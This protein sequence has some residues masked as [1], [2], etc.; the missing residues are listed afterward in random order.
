MSEKSIDL[1]KEE[2][3]TFILKVHRNTYAAP[4]EIKKQ[5]MAMPFLPGHK[6]CEFS[7]GDFTYRDSYAGSTWAPGSEVIFYTGK[8]VWRM[9]YQGRTY[10]SFDESF[11]QEK[12]FP[13]LKKALMK[14]SIDLPF[15]GPE[16]FYDGHFEYFFEIDG[17]YDYFKGKEYVLYKGKVVFFQDVMGSLIK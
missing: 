17:S 7:E 2:L 12:V 1:K 13:F 8:P 14:S 10:G 3:L 4:E 16:Y 5:N 6:D 11:F 15:R 9:S